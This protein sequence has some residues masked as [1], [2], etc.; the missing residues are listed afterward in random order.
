[1]AS[2]ALDRTIG[3]NHDRFDSSV[4]ELPLRPNALSTKMSSMMSA[5]YA[6]F[7][8]RDALEVLDQRGIDNSPETRRQLRLDVEKEVIDCNGEI[9]QE[10]GLVAKV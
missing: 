10:F 8:V 7:D 2:S 9:I 5:S 6:D 4:A 3:Q 1:M